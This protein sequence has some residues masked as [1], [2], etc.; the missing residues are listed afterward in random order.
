LSIRWITLAL[1]IAGLAMAG[2]LLLSD[3]GF[4]R[5]QNLRAAVLEQRLQNDLLSERNATLDAEVQ[6]LK[7]G[8]SA[9][10]ER[11][12]ADLG[13]IGQTETFYQVVPARGDRL[14]ADA[15]PR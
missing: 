10:E 13:M 7:H 8:K 15:T 2:R 11:A 6:N 9:A 4:S 12:R 5:T 3:A 1:G 14:I